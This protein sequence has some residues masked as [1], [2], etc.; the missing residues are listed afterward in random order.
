MKNIISPVFAIVPIHYVQI[1][2]ITQK[3]NF[4]FFNRLPDST[5]WLIEMEAVIEPAAL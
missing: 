3:I 2:A 4:S 1:A 5:F